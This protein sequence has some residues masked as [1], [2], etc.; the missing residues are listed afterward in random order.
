MLRY[1]EILEDTSSV[2]YLPQGL[3]LSFCLGLFRFPLCVQ[4]YPKPLPPRLKDDFIVSGTV[5]GT[6]CSGAVLAATCRHRPGRSL[7]PLLS[8]SQKAQYLLNRGTLN[9]TR[10]PNRI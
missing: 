6:G 4:S 3:E 5:L 1:L 7:A 2:L 9:D 10:I 8:E